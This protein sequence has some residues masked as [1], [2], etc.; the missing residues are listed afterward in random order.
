MG[1]IAPTSVGSSTALNTVLLVEDN[2][3]DAHPTQELLKKTSPIDFSVIHVSRLSGAPRRSSM[4]HFGVVLPDL[5]FPTCP[6][7][8]RAD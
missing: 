8:Y 5:S 1:L 4:E 3:G 6:A 2:E 7:S